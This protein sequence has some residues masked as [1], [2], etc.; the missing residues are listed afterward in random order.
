MRTRYGVKIYVDTNCP[1]NNYVDYGGDVLEC[2]ECCEMIDGDVYS[3]GG[4]DMCYRCAIEHYREP[5]DTEPC[6]NC[7]E[8]DWNDTRYVIDGEVVCQDCLT[9]ILL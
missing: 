9:A 7:G 1:M 4:K 5:G 2:D 3:V 8:Y 6:S